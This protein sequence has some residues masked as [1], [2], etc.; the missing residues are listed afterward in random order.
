[1][2]YCERGAVALRGVVRAET[3]QVYYRAELGFLEGTPLCPSLMVQAGTG[4]VVPTVHNERTV[5]RVEMVKGS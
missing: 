2:E 1:M 3:R 4:A 5:I